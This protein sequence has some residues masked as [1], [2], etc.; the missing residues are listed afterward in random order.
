MTYT[1]RIIHSRAH[2]SH[3]LQPL[4]RSSESFHLWLAETDLS[5]VGGDIYRMPCARHELHT[6]ERQA[7]RRVLAR[8]RLRAHL[9]HSAAGAVSF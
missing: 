1:C 7:K 8:A 3:F 6:R 2:N 5:G 4:L 9:L